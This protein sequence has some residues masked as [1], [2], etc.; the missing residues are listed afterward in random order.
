MIE[1]YTHRVEALQKQIATARLDAFLVTAT[2]SI[3]Y[4]TGLRYEPFERVF[5]LL[6][7]P[8]GEIEVVTPRIE[9]ENMGTIPV[10]HRIVEYTDYPAPAGETYLDALASV[11][12]QT[13]RVGVEPTMEAQLLSALGDWGPEVVPLIERLRLVKSRTEILQIEKAAHYSD[14]GLRMV[15]DAA[16]TGT[17]VQSGYDCIPALRKAIEDGEGRLDQYTS[18]IWLGAWASP[19]SAQPHRFPEPSDMYGPGPIVGLSFLRVN[20]YS[21]ETERTFFVEKPAAEE[22]EVFETMRAACA[23]AYERL[24]PGVS[25]HDVDHAVMT[26]LRREGFGDN[27]LHRT[28]HGIGMGGHEG[29]WV[30]EGSDDILAENMVISVEPGIYWRGEGGYRHSD[31]VL[32][33]EDGYRKLTE[34]S[35]TLDAMTLA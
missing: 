1:E 19:F 6:V 25:A 17:S 15:M 26:F 21:A 29:P 2:D 22:A 31:T 11:L 13:E 24:R 30:A 32:I 12:K 4:L 8:E 9:A 33:T 34:F 28:G 3:Y 16:K 14:L 18:S 7:R 5:F 23:I 20:G 27:L 35:D 10:Q